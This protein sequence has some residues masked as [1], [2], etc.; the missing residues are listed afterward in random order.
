MLKYTLQK[1]LERILG[2]QERRLWCRTRVSAQ[3]DTRMPEST[4][5]GQEIRWRQAACQC[6]VRTENCRAETGRR[7]RQTGSSPPLY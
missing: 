7:Q 4:S 2:E 5:A 3:V 6:L 1:T